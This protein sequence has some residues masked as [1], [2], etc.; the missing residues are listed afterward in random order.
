MRKVEESQN[1]HARSRSNSK[2]SVGSKDSTVSRIRLEELRDNMLWM[3][4]QESNGTT[5]RDQ[6]QNQDHAAEQ[7]HEQ[8]RFEHQN[9]AMDTYP[10]DTVRD[11][12]IL[13]NTVSNA[14]SDR[15]ELTR[16]VAERWAMEAEAN[17]MMAR[18]AA[19]KAEMRREEASRQYKTWSR[20]KLRA[21]RRGPD[22]DARVLKE[23]R[24]VPLE[25]YE[26]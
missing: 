20:N 17:V 24:D 26:S 6:D 1:H 5:T 23:V 2:A 4:K 16:Q 22:E 11:V 18:E 15:V 12:D 10:V 25:C 21:K 7:D 8:A 13:S 9:T 14:V 3:L 19:V